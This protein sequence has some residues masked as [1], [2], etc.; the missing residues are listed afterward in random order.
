MFTS[1]AG[2]GLGVFGGFGANI[3][4][5]C[6]LGAGMALAGACPGTVWPQLARCRSAQQA[7]VVAGGISGT[8]L[9]GY[10]QKVIKGSVP[11][12][13][14]TKPDPLAEKPRL[15]TVMSV[16]MLA[17][18]VGAVA[19]FDYLFPWKQELGAV[20]GGNAAE[21]PKGLWD[22]LHAGI[23]VGALQIPAMLSSGSWFGQSSG[24]VYASDRVASVFDRNVEKNAPYLRKARYAQR[25][26]WQFLSSIGAILGA[27]ISVQTS[28]VPAENFAVADFSI[29]RAYLG[30]VLLLLGARLGAGCTSGHG[31]SG[32]ATGS[33]GSMISVACMF[34]GGFVATQLV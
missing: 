20:V 9:F 6:L 11:R 18:T 17:C 31:L 22:P 28:T 34:A 10:M 24:W 12:F 32:V 27:Y 21:L 5:G 25:P 1:M 7:A 19:G 8:I 2:L 16:M 30:G 3:M 33:L 14:E 23:L 29:G 13:Q 4:G 26:Y 15:L